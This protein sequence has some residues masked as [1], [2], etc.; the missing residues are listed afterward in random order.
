MSYRLEAYVLFLGW[1]FGL[2]GWTQKVLD[3]GKEAALDDVS[4]VR[5]RPAETA[6]K[7]PLQVTNLRQKL[8]E[9]GVPAGLRPGPSRSFY[10]CQM[11]LHGGGRSAHSPTILKA[12]VNSNW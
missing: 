2:G 3:W 8:A 9:S 1:L 12:L 5:P 6:T 4:R 10:E 7:I 11:G